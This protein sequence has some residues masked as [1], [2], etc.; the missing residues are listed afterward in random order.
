MLC[1]ADFL[2]LGERVDDATKN[3]ERAERGDQGRD[4]PVGDD[5]SIN[6]PEKGAYDYRGRDQQRADGAC[7]GVDEGR[8]VAGGRHYRPDR[9]IE[10][11]GEYHERLR[12]RGDDQDRGG[13]QHRRDVRDEQEARRKSR[14]QRY[15]EDEDRE[16]PEIS[17]P[18][19]YGLDGAAVERPAPLDDDR[20][21]RLLLHRSLVSC[22]SL[23]EPPQPLRYDASVMRRCPRI[24]C[25]PGLRENYSA[26]SAQEFLC[27]LA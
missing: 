21:R 11:A 27:S 25:L 3:R 18:Q 24:P 5:R 22:E 17:R 13:E 1:G 2:A 7:V 8:N 19:Q 14:E 20:R 15:E 10:V 4:P 9:Q 23:I 16:R 26:L 6:E 12:Q